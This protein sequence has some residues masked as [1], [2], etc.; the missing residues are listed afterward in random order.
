[1]KTLLSLYLFFG[2]IL[3]QSFAAFFFS[4]G[5]TSYRRAFSAMVLCVSIYLFGYIM[6]IN[7]S[8]LEEMIFWNQVQYF[9]LPFISVL[10][11]MVALLYTRTIYSFKTRTAVLLFALPVLT[12]FLYGLPM[13]GT[14]FFIQDG[15]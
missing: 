8:T 12:F 13:T 7:S 9:G 10:W 6:V 5:R 4:K 15:K 1:V 14:I 2:V 3:A 11:M